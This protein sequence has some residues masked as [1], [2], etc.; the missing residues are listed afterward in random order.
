M[1]LHIRKTDIDLARRAASCVSL[2]EES[3]TEI[4]HLYKMST[5]ITVCLCDVTN[6]TTQLKSDIR[7]LMITRSDCKRVVKSESYKEVTYELV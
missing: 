2:N 6:Q 1:N 7:V 3:R 5:K 4:H